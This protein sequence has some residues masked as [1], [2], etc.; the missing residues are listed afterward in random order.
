MSP[1]PWIEWLPQGGLLFFIALFT[2]VVAWVFFTGSRTT[3]AQRANIPL[4]DGIPTPSRKEVN[5]G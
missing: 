1:P 5:H 2:A 3:W 4:D